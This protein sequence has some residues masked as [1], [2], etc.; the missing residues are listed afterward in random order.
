MAKTISIDSIISLDKKIAYKEC[1]EI[2]LVKIISEMLVCRNQWSSY[3]IFGIQLPKHLYC[4][5]D[6]T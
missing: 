3:V 1:A 5:K 2:C 6:A 4:N